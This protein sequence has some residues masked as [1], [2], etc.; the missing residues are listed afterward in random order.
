M[1]ITIEKVDWSRYEGERQLSSAGRVGP[2]LAKRAAH[3]SAE[4]SD[5][6]SE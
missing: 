2:V 4:I 3:M 6:H 5:G 1:D